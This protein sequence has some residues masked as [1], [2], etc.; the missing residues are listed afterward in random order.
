MQK[1]ERN[2]QLWFKLIAT[3]FAL[4]VIVAFGRNPIFSTS[5][6]SLFYRFI[7]ALVKWAQLC[8]ICGFYMSYNKNITSQAMKQLN[9]DIQ[10]TC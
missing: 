4:F 10:K 5:S 9:M 2:I 8:I 1:K 7:Y 3:S 6:S